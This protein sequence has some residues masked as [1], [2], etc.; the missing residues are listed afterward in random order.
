MKDIQE[1]M[2]DGQ[3]IQKLLG[4]FDKA[5]VLLLACF[6]RY[7]INHRKAGWNSYRNAGGLAK[8]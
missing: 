4:D 6:A 2:Y 8:C 1:D 5:L 7:I 3:V